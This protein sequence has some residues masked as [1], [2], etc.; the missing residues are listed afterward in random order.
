MS[1]SVNICGRRIGRGSI[2]KMVP[3]RPRILLHHLDD[4]Q[5]QY[6]RPGWYSKYCFYIMGIVSTFAYASTKQHSGRRTHPVVIKHFYQRPAERNDRTGQTKYETNQPQ[7]CNMDEIFRY[8]R[9]CSG[10]E[11]LVPWYGY[12]SRDDML[13]PREHIPQH[14]INS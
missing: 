4:I 12:K 11:Y 13:E 7:E 5:H 1:T 14:F 2:I 9:N 3:T 10:K 6:Y 8:F